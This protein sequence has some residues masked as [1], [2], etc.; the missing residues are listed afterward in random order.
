M[1]TVSETSGTTLNTP[2]FE[3]QGS[4]RRREKEGTEKIFEENI[5]ENF[6]NMGKKVVNQVQ[7]VQRVPYRI[8]PRRNMSRHM[9]IELSKIKYKEKISKAAREKQQ[10]THKGIPKRLR[11]DLSAE[12]LQARRE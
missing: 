6:P 1:R 7:E 10:I 12:T 9:L 11:A 3:L 8:K 5:V 4:Q 2:T